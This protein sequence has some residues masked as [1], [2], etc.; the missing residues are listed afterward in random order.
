MNVK[1]KDN[2]FS[3]THDQAAPWSSLHLGS[4][5]L[6]KQELNNKGAT[7]SIKLSLPSTLVSRFYSQKSLVR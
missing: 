3:L 6:K 4:G 1:F 7:I 2:F 5:Q